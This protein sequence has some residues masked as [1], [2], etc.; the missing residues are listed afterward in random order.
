MDVGDTLNLSGNDYEGDSIFNL[1]GSTG[2]TLNF[3]FINFVVMLR[4]LQVSRTVVGSKQK[5]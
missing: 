3:D 2:K 4:Y 5:L 1:T